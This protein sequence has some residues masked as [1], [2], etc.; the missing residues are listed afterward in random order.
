MSSSQSASFDPRE[1]RSALG[2]FATGVTVVTTRAGGGEPVG[3]T[4]NS[5]NSVSLEPPMVLWSL[6]R[7]SRSLPVFCQAT[8]WAVHILAADQEALSNRFAARGGDRFAGLTLE[9]GAGEVPLLCGCAA[10]FQCR[11][12]FQYEG[13]DHIIFVGEVLEFDRSNSPPLVFHGG[14]YA[15]TMQK[16]SQKEAPRATGL[17]GSF[18]EDFLG[19]LL[20][21]G[22]F[23][24]H[25][26]L[27]RRVAEAGISDDQYFVLATLTVHDRLSAQELDAAIAC[28]LAGDLRSALNGLQQLGYVG[29]SQ[30]SDGTAAYHL[31]PAGRDCALHLIAAGKSYEAQ[32]GEQFG[33]NDMAVLKSLLRRLVAATGP[34]SGRMFRKPS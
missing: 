6:A 27:R 14:R 33:S 9:R 11:T 13:G 12:A 21:R 22:H 18:S 2:S 30:A 10:R 25:Q 23:Q 32:L 17:A 16:A 26:R 19:Y 28:F 15:L 29:C 7:S 8:H 34:G 31:A 5:F 4:A 24:F 1:F 3:L 20:G